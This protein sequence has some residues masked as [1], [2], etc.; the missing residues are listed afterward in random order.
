MVLHTDKE[1]VMNRKITFF[2]VILS[3]FVMS[4]FFAAEPRNNDSKETVKHVIPVFPSFKTPA[5]EPAPI[6]HTT[7]KTDSFIFLTE[8]LKTLVP[9]ILVTWKSDR[10]KIKIDE[11]IPSDEMWTLKGL[12]NHNHCYHNHKT[13]VVNKLLFLPLIMKASR[14][15][16]LIRGSSFD[17][18]YNC[19]R[20]IEACRQKKAI[21]Y[22]YKQGAIIYSLETKGI[23]VEL[24][25]HNEDSLKKMIDEV[26]QEEE[27]RMF[28]V[29][30]KF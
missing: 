26:A 24:L 29:I 1:M 22:P 23:D 13:R 11:I 4:I 10:G 5:T 7:V 12:M 25:K 18:V 28:P 3:C 19:P 20:A 30:E 21:F 15:G 14:D 27:E 8:G 17:S 9:K 6:E 2:A 16:S